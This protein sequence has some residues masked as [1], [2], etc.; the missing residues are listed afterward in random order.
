MKK[1]GLR[2]GDVITQVNGIALNSDAQ[3]FAAYQDLI[4]ATRVVAKVR[5]GNR[6]I[7][8]TKTIE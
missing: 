2:R 7:E 1:L 6:T 5:R 3:A 4:Q 8:I